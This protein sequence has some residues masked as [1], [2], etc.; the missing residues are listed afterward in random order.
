MHQEVQ[1]VRKLLP[2]AILIAYIAL[3]IL[4]CLTS[5][6]ILEKAKKSN[7][8]WQIQADGL[9]YD[10]KQKIYHAEGHVSLTSGNKVIKADRITLNNTTHIAHLIGN[11]Y[12]RVARDWLKG[13]EGEFNIR[14]ETGTVKNGIIFFYDQHV[15][16]RSA[17]IQKTGKD[18]YHLE[19]GT[20]TTCDGEKPDWKFK[21]DKMDVQMSGR[22]VARKV[23]FNVG[24]IP[25]LY[26][27]YLNFPVKRERKSGFLFPRYSNSD[28]NGYGVVV[29][30]YWAMND[31]VDATFYPQYYSERGTMTGV[32]FRYKQSEN[33]LGMFR[34][35]Y[36]SDHKSDSELEK[37]GYPRE[38][39]ERWWWR[40]KSN[41]S[42]PGEIKGRLDVD[43]ASDKY[44]LREFDIGHISWDSSDLAFRKL[45]D[46]GLDNDKSVL[47]RESILYLTKDWELT[48]L[49]L[50]FHYWDNLDRRYDEYTLQQLPRLALDIAKQRIG[51]SPFFYEFDSE[52]MYYWRREGT[53]GQRVDLYPRVSLPYKWGKYLNIE[54]SFGAR[55][56]IY[57][58]D[59]EKTELSDETYDDVEARGIVDCRLDITSN[60]Q[61]IYDFKIGRLHGLKHTFRPEITYEFVPDI[62]QNDYPA[63]DKVDRIPK[64]NRITYGVSNFF[65]GKYWL[66]NGDYMYPE[67]GRLKIFQSYD[68][69]ESPEIFHAAGRKPFSDI[70]FE[71]DLDPC[72]YFS[73]SYDTAI[74]PYDAEWA[75][76]QLLVKMS[77]PRGDRMSIDYR[78]RP[79]TEDQINVNGTVVLSKYLTFSAGQQYS[80]LKDELFKQSYSATFARQCWSANVTY[81][82]EAD[83]QTWTFM[84]NLTGI[85]SIGRDTFGKGGGD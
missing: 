48:H 38:R 41:F 56:T 52:F 76:H 73:M 31:H 39:K 66:N 84:V 36:M 58:T 30:F 49:G 2:F 75:G 35:D 40:S 1:K 9:S 69:E 6:S 43:I 80:F 12:I 34:F 62:D 8:P 74:S 15:Y 67:I 53:K 3:L 79:D 13:E 17:I 61:R 10:S 82:D 4:P 32:E 42:L 18:T 23:S 50:E 22:G 5:A 55:G 77:S 72:Y 14:E 37:E 54:P 11:V 85:G 20:V 57:F 33:N 71:L 47:A 78:Q 70:T 44:F 83:K 51:T 25:I 46:R 64:Y 59:D 60:L 63:Y 19:K 21:F 81:T 65:I 68:I 16:I 7:L 24:G 29:P 26:T 45:L 27:P 28:L